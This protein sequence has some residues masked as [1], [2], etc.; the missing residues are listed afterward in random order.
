[1]ATSATSSGTFPTRINATAPV[2][3]G[4]V[5]I[6]ATTFSGTPATSSAGLLMYTSPLPGNVIPAT[7]FGM[8]V[9]GD[10]VLYPTVSI[11]NL[12]KQSAA[13]WGWIEPQPPTGSGCPGTV[14]CTHK[15]NWATLD[16]YVAN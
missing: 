7:F 11:G 9:H 14:N 8:N 16:D 13:Q 5:D 15:Y 3:S 12:G 2:G 4:T 10:P 1:G 6:A